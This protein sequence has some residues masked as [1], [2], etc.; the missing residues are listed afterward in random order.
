MFG[1]KPVETP[2]NFE[3]V[4]TL[5]GKDTHFQGVITATGTVRIDGSFQGEIKTKGD[6]V[7]GESGRVEAH[8]EGR[9]VLVGGYLKGNIVAS[10]KVDLSPSGKVFG[11][12]KVK[13][14]IIE[15]GAVFKGNCLM[16]KE[17]EKNVSKDTA[18]K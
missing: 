18:A 2:A 9:N 6:L 12:M 7:I 4:D 3:K 8:V 1:K 16:E 13:N 5:I 11:D 14:L 17:E 15:E 10:G